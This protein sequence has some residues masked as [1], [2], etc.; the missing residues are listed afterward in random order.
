MI[1][2]EFKLIGTA[3]NEIIGT[4][5]GDEKSLVEN[6]QEAERENLKL[7]TTEANLRIKR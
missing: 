3:V 7:T 4:L 6:L 2:E 1:Q 5:E